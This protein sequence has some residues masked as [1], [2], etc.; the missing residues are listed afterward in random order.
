MAKAR[1]RLGFAPESPCGVLAAHAL[2]RHMTP[3]ERVARLVNDGATAAAELDEHLVPLHVHVDSS[4][5]NA[6]RRRLMRLNR[7]RSAVALGGSSPDEPSAAA[8]LVHDRLRSIRS[9]SS[10]CSAGESDRRMRFNFPPIDGTVR[11]LG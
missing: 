8:T 7:W 4:H 2:E 11:G 5:A 10:F 3:E 9:E 1:G 6:C